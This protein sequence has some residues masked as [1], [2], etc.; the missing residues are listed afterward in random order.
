MFC[1]HA[2]SFLL[3]MLL[4]E[5][6]LP[7]IVARVVSLWVIAYFVLALK[8]VYGGAWMDT[9]VRGTTTVVLK[10]ASFLVTGALLVYALL[11]L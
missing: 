1:L 9:L 8:R 4:I 6:K 7:G 11:E 2:Q 10:I 5:A 3:V